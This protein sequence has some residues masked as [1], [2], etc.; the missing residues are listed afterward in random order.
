MVN[1]VKRKRGRNIYYYLQH[2]IRKDNIQREIYLGTKIPDNIEEIE[3]SFLLEFYRKQWIP[4]LEHIYESY[5]NRIKKI[6]KSVFEKEIQ[7]FAIN[8]TYNTDRIEGSTLT[9]HET[10]ALLEYNIS[11][12][13]RPLGDVKEAENHQKLFLQIIKEKKDLSLVTILGWHNRL[14]FQTKPDISGNIR[15][16]NVNIAR[17]KFI[18]PKAEAV[19]ILL[20]KFF[21]WYDSNKTRINP[22]EL[23]ALVHLKFV[24]I[25]PFGDGNGRISRLMMNFILNK[26]GYPMLDIRY[27]DRRSYYTALEKAQTKQNDIYFLQWFMRRYFKIHKEHTKTK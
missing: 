20:N 16:Y 22:V 7:N 5:T 24:S 12:A 23:A 9:L 4:T 19:K 11:P 10:A 13:N 17:S 26:Y 1:I 25:H 8:F 15:N 18:P 2:K 27:N 14:F 21:R 6:P 3:Q